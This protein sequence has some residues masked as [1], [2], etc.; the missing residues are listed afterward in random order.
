VGAE[1]TRWALSLAGGLYVGTPLASGIAL[2][3]SPEG[4]TWIALILA[5]T[6]TC[7][8]VAYAVGRR[9]GRHHFAT[10][11]SPGKSVEGVASGVLACIGVVGAGGVISGTGPGAIGLGLVVGVASVL[12]DLAESSLKRTF[13]AKDSGW[14]M[15]GHGG[16]LDR[17]DSLLFSSFLGYVYITVMVGLVR[18]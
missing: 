12:G 15:P 14:I 13:G 1:F 3:D 18:G 7:D 17:I 6:W 10:A 2:R 9:W 5:G 16:M 4:L 11:V 8:S